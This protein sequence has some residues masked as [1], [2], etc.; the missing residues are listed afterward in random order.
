[1]IDPFPPGGPVD[2]TGRPV[3]DKLRAALGQPVV[4]D[5]R[6]GGGSIIGSEAVA[7][8]EPD[9]YTFLLTASQHAINPSVYSKLPYD[10]VKAFLPVAM[11]AKGP[12]ILAV[13]PSVPVKDVRELIALAKSRP[14]KMN[15]GS[16]SSGS[17]FHMAGEM[18]KLM[19]GVDI[20]HIPYKGG[21][22]VTA[23]LVA[24]HVDM[25]FSSV[26]AVLP[27]I[28]AGRLKGLAVTTT[29]RS[30]LVPDFPSMA[31]AGLPGFEVDTW[32]GVFAPAG[33]P[34][35]IVDTMSREIEKILKE[36]EI[37]ELFA[38]VGVE[39]GGGSPEQFAVRIAKDMAKWAKVA[40]ESGAKVE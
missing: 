17:G 33:T 15:Y 34:R 8:A 4:I 7:R 21:A 2:V 25:A 12:F 9:G 37:R 30:P 3:L 16:A 20:V 39:P 24:G 40:K 28:R 13:H 26:V 6:P 10:T 22:P 38:K 5:F 36:M 18:F 27:H 14:G 31:E 29:E 23:D 35:E 1:M 19:A 32:Y 11:I